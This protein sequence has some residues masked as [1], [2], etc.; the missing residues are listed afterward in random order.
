MKIIS[1]NQ[2]K[3]LGITP[4]TCVDW[5]KESF[6]IKNKAQLPA[7]ISVHPQGN[8]FFTSMPCL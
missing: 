5:A 1:E 6:S 3:D 2:I 4:A 8:D 7:K